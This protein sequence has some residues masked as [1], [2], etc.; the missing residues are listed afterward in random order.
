MRLWVFKRHFSTIFQLYIDLWATLPG[1]NMVQGRNTLGYLRMLDTSASVRDISAPRQFG[2][3][4][5][6]FG[7]RTIRHLCFFFDFTYKT[8]NSLEPIPN[9]NHV[10]SGKDPDHADSNPDPRSVIDE[11][12]R[13]ILF[14]FLVM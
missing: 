6:H 14:V 2:T 12:K 13:L 8:S 10:C 9:F 11:K 3:C 5:R 4:A 1:T 7:T